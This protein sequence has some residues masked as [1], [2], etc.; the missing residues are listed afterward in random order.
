MTRGIFF[1]CEQG[2]GLFFH[3]EKSKIWHGKVSFANSK[4]TLNEAAADATG[5]ERR[6]F[7]LLNQTFCIPVRGEKASD[8]VSQIRGNILNGT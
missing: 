6:V 1:L 5:C 7:T 2:G 3:A 4:Q 8:S